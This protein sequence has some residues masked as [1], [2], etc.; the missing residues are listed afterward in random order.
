MLNQL[1]AFILGEQQY[2]LPLTA[3][4]RVVRMVE[5]TPL[6]KAP[7]IVLG[8]IDFQG[9]ILPIMS[10]RK[11]FGLPEPETSLNDQLIVADTA[12]R[13]LAL[14]VNSVTGVLERTAE[15]VT[16]AEKIVPGAQY[17][18][19]ITRLKG[20]ILFIHNLEHFLSG[21][22]EQQL[23]DLLAQAAGRE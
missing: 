2:A 5:V 4:Q 14:V 15:E 17:V 9:T 13:R 23:C 16:E 10:M 19:G 1:V 11:R 8:V 7:E 12:T 21:K 18:E 6:P 3:V 22:E 20:G